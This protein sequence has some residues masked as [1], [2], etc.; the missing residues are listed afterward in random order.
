MVTES[1]A[2]GRVFQRI[3]VKFLDAG[4]ELIGSLTITCKGL[5][6]MRTLAWPCL[7][8]QVGEATRVDVRNVLAA[9]YA[10]GLA[11]ASDAYQTLRD[12]MVQLD[13]GRIEVREP[14]S[15]RRWTRNCRVGRLLAMPTTATARRSSSATLSRS[16]SSPFELS[17]HPHDVLGYG[18]ALYRVGPRRVD[19]DPPVTLIIQVSGN[20]LLG[21]LDQVLAVTRRAGYRS[22]DLS[23]TRRAPF[24][25]AERGCGS[26][27]PSSTREGP[28]SARSGLGRAAT[29]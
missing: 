17:V 16:L 19:A 29:P 7:S 9:S 24:Q 2:P 25:I 18:V 12:V 4:R 6:E 3:A 22:T 28:I 13:M 23:A 27:S 26:H 8:A 20:L 14:R 21:T 11:P 1:G 15:A 10:D 5:P